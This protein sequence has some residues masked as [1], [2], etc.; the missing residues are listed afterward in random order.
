MGTAKERELV[1]T[2]KERELVGTAKERARG[3]R[4][5]EGARV[6]RRLCLLTR[7]ACFFKNFISKQKK[8]LIFL[9]KFL[10]IIFTDKKERWI[11]MPDGEI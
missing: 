10:S 6:F 4:K 11:I 5:R 1:G 3:H 2:A 9:V 7:R 8:R